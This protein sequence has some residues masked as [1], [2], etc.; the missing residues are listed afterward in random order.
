VVSLQLD[1]FDDEAYRTLR[2][3]PLVAEK[4]RIL[5]LLAE[6]GISTSLT[7][8]MAG[9]VNDDQLPAVLAC[10]FSQPHVVSLM[11]QPLSFAGRGKQLAGVARRLSIPEIIALVSK[12]GIPQVSAEDFSPL[13]CSHP[14]CFSLAFYLMLDGGGIISLSRLV[15]TPEWLDSLA[16]RTVFGLDEAEQARMKDM[17]NGIWSR[18]ADATPLQG[19]QAASAALCPCMSNRVMKT[20]RGIL[21]EMTSRQFEPR[22]AFS[23][24]ER[25]IKSIF[26]H[27]FQDAE[28]FDLARVR[29]C[30]NGYPQPDGRLM[31]A[32]M[33][34]V[35]GR[36]NGRGARH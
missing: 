10:L 14:L 13:P 19:Q 35:I 16:N 22:Q 30:C 32:C 27:A 1:G 33:H 17:I 11:I 24:T 28:T 31:P 23:I 36:R 20:L 21:D 7:M 2:G 4:R 9:G 8:T 15:E 34:N 29:R 5:D 18:T 3:R 6:A 25:R 12:A 26:I